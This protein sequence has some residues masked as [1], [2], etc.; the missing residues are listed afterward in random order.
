MGKKYEY[1]KGADGKY[2]WHCKG[3]NGEVVAQG[4]GYTEKKEC[5]DAIKFMKATKT[6]K[7]VELPAPA[8]SDK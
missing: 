2:Y 5:L 7:V 6:A 4:Q 8:V 3:R 1:W